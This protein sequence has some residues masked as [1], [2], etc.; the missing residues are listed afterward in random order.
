M[1]VN[2]I[3]DMLRQRRS[4]ARS[5]RNVVRKD[6]LPCRR[7]LFNWVVCLKFLIRERL[8]YRKKESWDRNTPSNS[9]GARGTNKSSASCFSR[10]PLDEQRVRGRHEFGFGWRTPDLHDIDVAWW[11]PLLGDSG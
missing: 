5:Q 8:F 6:Q 10:R 7:S 9:P 11:S 1:A 2:A 3:F 4:P